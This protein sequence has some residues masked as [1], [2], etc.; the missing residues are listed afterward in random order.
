MAGVIA[1]KL[2]KQICYALK[3]AERTIKTHRARVMT[4][5]RVRSVAELVRLTEDLAAEGVAPEKFP[6]G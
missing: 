5:M 2:N 1:G 4:K 6:G 3:A